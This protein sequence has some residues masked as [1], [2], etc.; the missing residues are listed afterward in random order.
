MHQFLDGSR[1]L[2][3]LHA[4]LRHGWRKSYSG[5]GNDLY[6]RLALLHPEHLEELALPIGISRNKLQEAIQGP[7]A[8]SS[9]SGLQT[10]CECEELWGYKCH[11]DEE[12]QQDHLFPYSMGGPTLQ[13]NRVFLCKLHNLAKSND[14]HILPWKNED[15]WFKPWLDF[16]IEK[17]RSL[18]FDVYPD[19]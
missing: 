16:Q 10:Y 8:F 4:S 19:L 11:L 1:F 6:K 2:Q 7:R 13:L 15:R 3:A 5:V 18:A 9:S 12:I 14:I 17:C